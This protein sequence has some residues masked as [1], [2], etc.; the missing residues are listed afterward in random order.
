MKKNTSKPTTKPS[1]KPK[2]KSKLKNRF[3]YMKSAVYPEDYPKESTPEIILS[4]RSNSGKSSF[5]NAIAGENVAKVSQVPGKTRLLNFFSVRDTSG[6]K[7]RVV[8]TPGYGFSRRSGDE[9]ASWQEMVEDYFSSRG[10]L[11][12]VLLLMDGRREWEPEERLLLQ[13]SQRMNVPLV[14]LLN[15][16]DKMKIGEIQKAVKRIQKAAQTQNVFPISA[17]TGA[18]IEEIED[19]FFRSWIRPVILGEKS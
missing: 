6:E 18:G 14:V 13:F 15:K 7:Y 8:D 19:F 3:E 2:A 1:Q 12:G 4:G 10:T 9:Q 16:S 11:C 17:Q 5:L